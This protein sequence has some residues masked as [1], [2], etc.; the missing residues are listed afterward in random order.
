MSNEAPE[1]FG[2]Q[3][4]RRILDAYGFDSE[5]ELD[6][7][8]EEELPGYLAAEAEYKARHE[9]YLAALPDQVRHAQQSVTSHLRAAGLLPD[10]VEFKIVPMDLQAD[11]L[12][13]AQAT[14]RRK[15]L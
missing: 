6:A 1:D 13:M 15:D 11:A 10:N 12:W 9:A 3:V 4:K 8:T 7:A 2:D 14:W 5:G